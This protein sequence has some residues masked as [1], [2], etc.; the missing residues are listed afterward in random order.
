MEIFLVVLGLWSLGVL[1]ALG[2]YIKKNQLHTVSIKPATTKEVKSQITDAVTSVVNLSM[3]EDVYI[4]PAPVTEVAESAPKKRNRKSKITP[5]K[6]VSK[7]AK[8]VTF[9]PTRGRKKKS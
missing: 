5:T 9:K 8:K 6:K 3:S 1:I 2:L 7:E 4:P